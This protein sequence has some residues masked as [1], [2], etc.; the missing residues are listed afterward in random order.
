MKLFARW[1]ELV[2][3]VYAILFCWVN[4]ARNMTDRLVLCRFFLKILIDIGGKVELLKGSLFLG[5][6]SLT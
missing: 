6:L 1:I 4:F 2:G 3:E 5:I